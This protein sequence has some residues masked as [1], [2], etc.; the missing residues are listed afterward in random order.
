MADSSLDKIIEK[1]PLKKHSLQSIFGELQDAEQAYMTDYTED[2]CK[3]SVLSLLHVL[4]GQKAAFNHRLKPNGQRLALELAGLFQ[5]VEGDFNYDHYRPL[6]RLVLE[7]SPDIDIWKAVLDLIDN[8]TQAA[9]VTPPPRAA[10]S[11]AQTPKSYNT[12]GLVNSSEYRKNIDLVLKHE[13]LGQ[14]HSDVDGFLDAFFGD[15]DDGR[16]IAQSVFDDF[17]AGEHPFFTEE[18]GWKDWPTETVEKPVLCFLSKIINKLIEFAE[19]HGLA[20]KID[21]RAL[22]QPTTPVCG[23]VGQR[24]LDICFVDDPKATTDSKYQWSEIVVPGE[25]KNDKSYDSPSQARLDLARYAREVLSAQDGRRFVPGFTLSGPLLR[26]WQF[27]RCGGIGSKQ[28]DI[29][30]DG[31]QFI[32]VL[33][34]FLQMDRKQLGFDPTIVMEDG[35]RW[36]HIKREG[37]AERLA[38]DKVILYPHCVAGRATTCWRAHAEN[39]NQTLVVKD[40]WQYPERDHEGELLRAATEANVVN[41][42]R[43]Y[44]HEIV[45]INRTDD[46][47]RVIRKHL[48]ITT[49]RD[50]STN[51][52]P[53]LIRARFRG[54]GE[55]SRSMAGQKRSLDNVS[56]A[57]PARKRSQ[58][59]LIKHIAGENT[60]YRVHR[61]VV[62]LDY[63]KPLYTASSMVVLLKGLEDCI[64]GYWSLYEKT[65]MIQCDISTGNLMINENEDDSS[66]GSFLIDLDLAIKHQRQELSGTCGKTG[67]RAFMAIGVLYGDKHSYM[68][69]LESFFWVLFWICIH[70][71]KPGQGRV[72]KRFEK[73]NYLDTEELADIKKG[74][75]NHER[76][77]LRIIE[78]HFTPFYKPLSPWVNRLRRLVFPGDKRWERED[79]SLGSNMIKVLRDAQEDPAIQD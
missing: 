71:E 51:A 43:Y 66:W 67:T 50:D 37:Q 22:A 54:S 17:K 69:D 47:T 36:I 7:D 74:V 52:R 3:N 27:D 39:S 18:G 16:P 34:G 44:H 42:A 30:K 15:L 14:L 57:L 41:V 32:K 10:P 23:S 73:W 56:T 58:P 45:Q 68:H 19:Q 24:K 12:S 61:R 59:S 55:L 28:I 13:L 40:S 53:S 65:G 2:T 8:T 25:L 29:N 62:L 75:I 6:V 60:Q 79:L 76:D 5:H 77:F 64:Q 38:I 46:D 9:R 48:N 11:T 33:L 21:R 26:I 35:K 4:Q 20:Q 63:G 78:D 1:Y 72:V 70:Y 31:L 49:A